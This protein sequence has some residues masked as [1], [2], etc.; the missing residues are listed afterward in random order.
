MKRKDKAYLFGIAGA[1]FLWIFL[2]SLMN[3]VTRMGSAV[4]AILL[5][6]RAFQYSKVEEE[7]E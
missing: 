2:H 5:L 4:A 1:I 3:G 7:N 6:L